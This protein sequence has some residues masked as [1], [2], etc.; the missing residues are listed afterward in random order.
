MGTQKIPDLVDSKHW[1]IDLEGHPEKYESETGYYPKKLM[2]D[3]RNKDQGLLLIYVLDSE[4]TKSQLL[5][6]R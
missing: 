1:S 5:V 6:E 2:L 3:K 4:G